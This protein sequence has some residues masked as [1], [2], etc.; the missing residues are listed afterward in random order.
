M[1]SFHLQDFDLY[2]PVPQPLSVKEYWS[3]MRNKRFGTPEGKFLFS[4]FGS[5]KDVIEDIRPFLINRSFLVFYMG[6][7]GFGAPPKYYD[8]PLQ[9][10][11][12]EHL[13]F[14]FRGY[15]LPR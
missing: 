12:V 11:K 5:Q 3:F 10:S 2:N 13:K 8:P 15:G 1:D 14:N 6:L 9:L 4:I 7:Y